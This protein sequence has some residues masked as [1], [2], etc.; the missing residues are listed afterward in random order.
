MPCDACGAA[1]FVEE[2]QTCGLCRHY[3]ADTLMVRRWLGNILIG[4]FRP[5]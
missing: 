1:L 2:S 3:E 4:W 5:R